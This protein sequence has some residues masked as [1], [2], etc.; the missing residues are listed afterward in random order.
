[1]RIVDRFALR[2]CLASLRPPFSKIFPILR[3]L[4]LREP[5]G[6]RN[7]GSQRLK[8][9]YNVFDFYAGFDILLEMRLS[10]IGEQ[11]YTFVYGKSQPIIFFHS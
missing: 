8:I 2:F 1:V 9:H 5:L 3:T 7:P 11:G 10:G 6:S 4:S